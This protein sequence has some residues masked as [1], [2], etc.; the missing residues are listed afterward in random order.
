MNF[1]L[2]KTKTALSWWWTDTTIHLTSVSVMKL[3]SSWKEHR[4]KIML[5]DTFIELAIQPAGICVPPYMPKY[6]IVNIC[7]CI[8]EICINMMMYTYPKICIHL[9]MRAYTHTYLYIHTQTCV[10][11]VYIHPRGQA[12]KHNERRSWRIIKKCSFTCK[13]L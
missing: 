5:Q 1:N 6:A 7:K 4:K 2:Q 11:T 10:V 12:G 9:Y 13:I 8:F 3:W